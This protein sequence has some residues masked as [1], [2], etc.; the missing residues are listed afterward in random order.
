MS[1]FL[2]SLTL[3]TA[4][5]GLA[6]VAAPP[7]IAAPIGSHAPTFHKFLSTRQFADLFAPSQRDI[8]TITGYLD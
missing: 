3:S 4:F 7:A 6:A 1:R 2:R 8:A 5:V